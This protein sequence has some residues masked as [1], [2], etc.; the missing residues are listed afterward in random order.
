MKRY[1]KCLDGRH[2]RNNS[3]IQKAL[4]IDGSSGGGGSGA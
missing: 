3:L 1:A 4:G 2:E